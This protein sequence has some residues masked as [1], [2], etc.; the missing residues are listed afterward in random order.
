MVIQLDFM[1]GVLYKSKIHY[2]ANQKNFA[3]GISMPSIININL[4]FVNCKVM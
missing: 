3:H 2:A 1:D 4:Y